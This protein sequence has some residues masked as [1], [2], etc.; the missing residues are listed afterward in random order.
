MVMG[1]IT[2]TGSLSLIV[3]IETKSQNVYPLLYLLIKV[4]KSDYFEKGNMLAYTHIITLKLKIPQ[5][6]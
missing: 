2:K 5:V 4:K 1:T 6:I 3:L